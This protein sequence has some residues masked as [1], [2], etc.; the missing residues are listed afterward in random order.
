MSHLMTFYQALFSV[1]HKCTS[2]LSI[3]NY[4]T[5]INQLCLLSHK[6]KKIS[7][8]WSYYFSIC[9]CSTTETLKGSIM[10]REKATKLKRHNFYITLLSLII[11]HISSA[12]P[13]RAIN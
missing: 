11:H 12:E 5:T 10:C 4:K 6:E 9:T 1:F 7:K 13:S 8:Q 2:E 3:N